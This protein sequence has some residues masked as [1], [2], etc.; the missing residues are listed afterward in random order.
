MMEPTLSQQGVA[1]IAAVLL[2][3]LLAILL[4][5]NKRSSIPRVP[6][7]LPLVGSGVQYFQSPAQFCDKHRKEL[8]NVFQATIFGR[9]WFFVFDKQDVSKMLR[10]NEK[11]VSMY[12]GLGKLIGKFLPSDL[13]EGFDPPAVEQFVSRGADWSG[14]QSTPHFVQALKPQRLRAWIPGLRQMLQ[15]DMAELPSKGKVNLFAWCS[16]L[17]SAITARVSLGDVVAKDRQMSRAWIELVRVAEPESAFATPL[18]SMGAL[19]EIALGGERNVYG[20]ARQ[21]LYPFIDAE[22]EKCL[23]GETEGSDASVLA[24]LV[25]AWYKQDAFQKNPDFLRGARVRIANDLFFFTFAAI[26]NSYAAAAWAL[27]HVIRNTGGIGDRVRAE[28]NRQLSDDSGD[29]ENFPELENLLNEVARLYTPGTLFRLLM[30][31]F[32]VP[33]TGDIIPAGN[34]IAC[35]VPAAHRSPDVYAQPGDFDPTR[36][37]NKEERVRAAG[38]FM[39]FGA[40]THPCVGRRFAVLEIALFVTEALKQFDWKL[41][42]KMQDFDEYTHSM[43]TNVPHHPKLDASQNNSIWRPIGPVW[44]QYERKRTTVAQ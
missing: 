30:R 31:D 4:P 19:V 43:I 44:V 27:W 40:G 23:A 18:S 15:Q 12:Q 22:I 13:A 17:I 2:G 38:L 41:D 14:I 6:S 29:N 1:T 8:G 36:F 10:A 32:R 35:S 37:E 7:W 28:L 42:N 26:T 24:G 21:F 20:R 5:K 16:D 9:Q 25:R 34:L 11:N 39:T 33:S 3:A